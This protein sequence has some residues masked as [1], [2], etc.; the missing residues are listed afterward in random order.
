[1]AKK[2]LSDNLKK[3]SINLKL[4]RDET[5]MSQREVG[6][7]LGVMG[8]TV[9]LWETGARAPSLEMVSR[10]ADLYDTSVD[11]LLGRG[12]AAMGRSHVLGFIMDKLEPEQQ[13]ALLYVGV[14]MISM[15]PEDLQKFLAFHGMEI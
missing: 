8:S 11:L 15:P 10:L 9:A 14:S 4:H 5:G 2:E 13:K 1:M 7:K 12:S 6:E 3:L